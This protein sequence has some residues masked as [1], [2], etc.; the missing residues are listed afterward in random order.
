MDN[1]ALAD[2]RLRVKLQEGAQQLS[3]DLNDQ[4]VTAHVQFLR[5]IAKWNRVHNLTAVRSTDE[6]VGRHL[7]DSLSVLKWL[8]SIDAKASLESAGSSATADVLDVGTGAGLP[9]IPLAIMRPDLQ[10]LSVESNGKKTR[11]QHQAVTDLKLKN[12]RVNQ[13]RIEDVNEVAHVIVSRAFTAPEGFLQAIDKNC[14]PTSQV[15]IMLGTIERM[16]EALP[17]PFTVLEL[18]EMNIPQFDSTRHVA[19]CGRIPS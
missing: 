10:F 16:P 8:P 6:M 9:V 2:D 12:V 7:L 14:I 17:K 3:I 5:L 13:A 19:V 18:E 1:V 15:I 4:Q 11:F